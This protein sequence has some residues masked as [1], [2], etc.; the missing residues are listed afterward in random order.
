MN[1][2]KA[3]DGEIKITDGEASSSARTLVAPSLS[4]SRRCTSN[5]PGKLSKRKSKKMR[6]GLN[7]VL[8]TMSNIIKMSPITSTI[9]KPAKP[10]VTVS[11]SDFVWDAAGTTNATQG[12]CWYAKN[13]QKMLEEKVQCQVK[14]FTR[15]INRKRRW[16]TKNPIQAVVFHLQSPLLHTRCGDASPN[17][18]NSWHSGAKMKQHTSVG[19]ANWPFRYLLHRIQH[20]NKFDLLF[21]KQSQIRDPVVEID[22]A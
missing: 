11:N 19:R 22:E 9:K 8:A 7:E 21:L 14:E 16:N 10:A 15:K 17:S 3:N 5:W 6:K 20:C 2:K 12:I 13:K 1:P 18:P 4:Q